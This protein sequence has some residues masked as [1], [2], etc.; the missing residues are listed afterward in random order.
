MTGRDICNN[1]GIEIGAFALGETANDDEVSFIL[2]KLNRLLDTW[3][4]KRQML[5]NVNFT[6]FTLTANLAPHTIGLST[7]TPAPTLAV[8]V[9]RPV[10]VEAAAIIITSTSNNVTV[11]LNLR[12]DEWWANERVKSLKSTIPTDLYY[13]PDWPNGALNFWPIPN[14][15]YGLEI[16]LQVLLSSLALDTVFSLPQGY[17]DAITLTLAESIAEPFGKEAS[18][19]L[20]SAAMRA[21]A[22]IEANNNQAGPLVTLMAGMPGAASVSGNYLTGGIK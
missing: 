8:P 11:P 17:E 13:S 2:G 10:S 20:Q 15:A 19:K 18:I 9:A 21:R 6:N 3:N 22:A 12:N 1:A 5:Y 4:A 7:N 14:I 16:E